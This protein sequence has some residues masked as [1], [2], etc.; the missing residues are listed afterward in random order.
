MTPEAVMDWDPPK[1]KSAAIA[2][3]DDLSTLSVAELA[4]R[5]E[6]LKAEIARTEAV[7][8]DKRK[9]NAAADALFGKPA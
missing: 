5:V 1:P 3:G 6:K 2:I 9:V 4:D 8:A 7:A